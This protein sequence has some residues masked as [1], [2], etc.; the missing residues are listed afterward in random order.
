MVNYD[1]SMEDA[2]TVNHSEN[3]VFRM[4]VATVL[5]L[6]A[7]EVRVL[8]ARK[9]MWT[10]IQMM[11]AAMKVTVTLGVPT[12]VNSASGRRVVARMMLDVAPGFSVT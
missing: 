6:G 10:V 3:F 5:V 2:R 12:N 4:S 9:I 11:N 7:K 1:V 8:N